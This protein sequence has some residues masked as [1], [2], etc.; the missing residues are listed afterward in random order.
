MNNLKLLGIDVT[1]RTLDNTTY[2]GRLRRF[3]FDVVVAALGQVGPPGAEQR[4]RWGSA[5]AGTEGSFNWA[6]IKNPA[7][8]AMI[9]AVVAAKDEQSYMDALHALDRVLVWNFYTV[10]LFNGNN[11]YPLAWWDRFGMTGKPAPFGQSYV[12]DW[13]IDP[14]KDAVLNAAMNR[15]PGG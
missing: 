12:T 14:K 13:W 9:D 2:I 15:A 1:L 10:P 4:D 8:D 5:A 7:V 3:D 6:G 11:K